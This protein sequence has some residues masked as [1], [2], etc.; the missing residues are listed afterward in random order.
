[1][2][3]RPELLA[4]FRKFALTAPSADALMQH[5]SDTLHEKMVRYNW[6]GFY[7]IDK[8]DAAALVLGPFS[9]TFTPHQRIPLD[10]GL[11]GAAASSGKT[12]VVDDVTKD[13]RYLSG[14]EHTKSEMIAPF[15]VRGRVAGE[16][17]I[18]SYFPNTF[19][20]ADRQFVESCAAVV[21]QY[22]ETHPAG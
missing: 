3:Q 12:V 15:K 11:C 8:E 20:P 19:G 18:N 13:P 5:I 10:Q 6:V 4:Q 21:A 7:L 9:G 17:D 14:S 2:D 1:M 22:L 16:L